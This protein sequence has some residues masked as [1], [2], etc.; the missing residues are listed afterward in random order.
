[1]RCTHQLR[2]SLLRTTEDAVHSASATPS[3][4]SLLELHVRVSHA[5]LSS[6]LVS[7]TG[8]VLFAFRRGDG[9]WL[10]TDRNSCRTGC[11]GTRVRLHLSL[12]VESEGGRTS[13]N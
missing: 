3:G 12:Q 11:V 4:V 5:Q 9:D 8:R 13:W 6:L 7:T 2:P 1:M 10:S